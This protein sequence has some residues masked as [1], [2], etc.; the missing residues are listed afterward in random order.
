MKCR[1]L[2]AMSLTTYPLESGDSLSPHLATFLSKT[3]GRITVP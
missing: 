2:L 3:L 1:A